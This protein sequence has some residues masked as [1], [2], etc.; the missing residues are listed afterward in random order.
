MLSEVS[1]AIRTS[2]ES[3]ESPSPGRYEREGDLVLRELPCLCC[4]PARSELLPAPLPYCPGGARHRTKE[5]S[6]ANWTAS[7]V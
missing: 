1:T 6:I 2:P 5:C 7:R 4:P 3:T